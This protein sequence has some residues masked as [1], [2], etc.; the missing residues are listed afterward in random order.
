MLLFWGQ[1]EGVG[2]GRCVEPILFVWHCAPA[3]IA[4]EAA[5]GE[6]DV[7]VHMVDVGRYVAVVLLVFCEAGVEIRG[8]HVEG[9]YFE[10]LQPFTSKPRPVASVSDASRTS[11]WLPVSCGRM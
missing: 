6:V 2:V 11:V 8:Q 10:R 3:V 4:A 9:A 7:E 1:D 5:L